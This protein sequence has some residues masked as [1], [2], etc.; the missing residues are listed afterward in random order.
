MSASLT[1]KFTDT[2][3]STNPNVARV[4]STRTAG[5]ATLA[6][7]NLAGWPTA[8]KVHFSTYQLNTSDEVVAGTQIDWEGI[9]SANSIGSLTRL[10][11]ATDAGSAIGDVVEMNPTGYWGHDLYSGL[12]AEHNKDGTHAAVTAT[13]VTATGTV[14]GATVVATGDIQ[15][16]SVSLETIRS[17]FVFDHVAS[18]CVWTADA[19][20]STRNASMTAGVV[21][22]GGKRVAVS[23]VTARSFTASK[24]VYIDVD[25]TGTLT[26]TDTTTNA[27][28]PALAANSIRLGIIVVGASNIATAA[29]VNQG[30]EDRVLPI[31]S[32]IPYAVTDSL[33]NLI[34]PRDPQ[35]KILG[36]RQILSS[37]SFTTNATITG[38]VVPVIV[39]TGRKIKVSV[40]GSSFG[41]TAAANMASSIYDGATTGG[42]VVGGMSSF[43]TTANGFPSALVIGT[44]VTPS[45]ASKTYSV[46]ASASAGTGQISASATVPAYIMVEL[47]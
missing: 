7:D 4:T 6:C 45:S 8:T 26:Y 5:G 17:N 42:T 2:F 27:A 12:T 31:A 24:D 30:Q 11:G 32:S 29:S 43:V 40:F 36:Y 14:Q 22:I 16:R 18:G 3:N 15:H 38:L 41:T 46:A 23:S 39:P 1:D 10:A 33:G 25:N 28:S 13:S 35:R 37:A 19:A 44:V 9:V 47:V 34:C 21:Y 20:G